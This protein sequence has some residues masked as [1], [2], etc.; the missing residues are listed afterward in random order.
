MA[1][2]HGPLRIVADPAW[3]W[4]AG[5][6]HPPQ[7]E[8]PADFFAAVQL[9]QLRADPALTL[10]ELV[11]ADGSRAASTGALP[12]AD[13]AATAGDEG[14]VAGTHARAADHAGEAAPAAASAAEPSQEA[15]EG[16]G[17]STPRAA[18]RAR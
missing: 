3:G 17:A 16:A 1:V 13:G 15:S 14:S 18:R 9:D 10:E 8:Y 2:R 11:Q 5:L 4:C 7:A 12:P 6:R